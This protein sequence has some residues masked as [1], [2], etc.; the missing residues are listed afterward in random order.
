MNEPT[1][2]LPSAVQSALSRGDKL[3]AIKLL[4]AASGLDLKAAKD[5]VERGGLDTLI[6]PDVAEHALGALP[7][8]V[9]DAMRQGQ[10]IEAIRLLREATGMG[11]KEAKQAVEA[12]PFEGSGPQQSLGPGEVP[13]PR[14]GR[15]LG[16]LVVLVVMALAYGWW[17]R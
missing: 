16:L 5:A 8:T 13:R 6:P 12:L 10:K 11:L 14:W 2:P 9:L 15:W 1:H 3:L 7:V 17:G 4:R